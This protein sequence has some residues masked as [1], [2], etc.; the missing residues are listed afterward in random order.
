M[1]NIEIIENSQKGHNDLLLEIPE[2]IG[3][4]IL[5]SYYLILASEGKR[6][7]GNAKYTLVQLLTFWYQKITQ[8]KEGQIIYL[9]IDFNDEYTAGLKVEKDQDLILSYGYSLKMC[10]YSVNPLESS[11][12]YN[13]VT[14]FQAENDNV[15]IVK[16]QDFEEGLK[17]LI[18]RLER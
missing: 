17:G 15:L 13:N 8:L 10:G 6:K 11:D 4:K 5:D 18:D 12:Y 3:K 14:D 16:Q 2:L 1:I 9:P 7:R